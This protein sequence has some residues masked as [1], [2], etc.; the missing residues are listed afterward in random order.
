[1]RTR[2]RCVKEY[3]EAGKWDFITARRSC[4][5]CP[6]PEP[7][8]WRVTRVKFASRSMNWDGMDR[9]ARSVA[10]KKMYSVATMRPNRIEAEHGL[11]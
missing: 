7:S 3:K 2:A 1:M 10:I 11:A 8:T 6:L 4:R 9:A 5:P